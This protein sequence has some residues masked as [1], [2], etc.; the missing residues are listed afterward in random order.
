MKC[1]TIYLY[2]NVRLFRSFAKFETWPV[3]KFLNVSKIYALKK[4]K[5]QFHKNVIKIIAK[6]RLR[7]VAKKV[8]FAAE[9]EGFEAKNVL[10]A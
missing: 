1:V 4:F 2:L 10:N 3:T 6:L 7:F 8:C 9:K 5:Q